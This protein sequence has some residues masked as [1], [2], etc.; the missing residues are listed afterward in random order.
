[1]HGSRRAGQHRHGV[2][3]DAVPQH[4]GLCAGAVQLLH[5]AAVRHGAA[6]HAVEARHA[7]GRIL[8]LAGGHGVVDRHVGLGE[9]RS[10]S[11]ALYRAFAA[12]Q[13]HGGEHV[14]RAVVVD[15]L[16]GGDGRG[17]HGDQAEA[18]EELA[19]L[20][21]GCTEIPSEGHLPLYQRP[22]FWAGWWPWCSSF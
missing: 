16:R 19:G 8:G 11:A 18:R 14:P 2:P 9:A 3:G 20:V 10:G 1:M 15:H 13:G 4:H 12:C 7:G 5:R 6:G 21:Y 17:Q 22:I